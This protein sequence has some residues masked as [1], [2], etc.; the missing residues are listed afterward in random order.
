MPDGI[1]ILIGSF[2]YTIHFYGYI[3]ISGGL[4]L[5]FWRDTKLNVRS[6]QKPYLAGIGAVTISF[7]LK[8]GYR[9]SE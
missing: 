3:L 9:M 6:V 7:G 8:Q 4:Q 1:L 2:T 5:L